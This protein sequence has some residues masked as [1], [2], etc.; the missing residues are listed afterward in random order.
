MI[1][2]RRTG[3]RSFILRSEPLA[4]EVP[5]MSPTTLRQFP[6]FPVFHLATDATSLSTDAC[7]SHVYILSPKQFPFAGK[8]L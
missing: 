4:G 6:G 2:R 3:L 8:K 7:Q 1:L 5:N